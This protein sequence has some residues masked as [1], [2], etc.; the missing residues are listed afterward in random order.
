MTSVAIT[1]DTAGI[2]ND[3]RLLAA[4]VDVDL[5]RSVYR[6]GAMLRTRV[7]AAASGRPGPRVQTG[8]Y[9]R[10][11][12]QTNTREGNVPVAYVHTNMPQG[13][14][15]EYGFTGRDALG[16][17]YDQ[18]PYPHWRPASEKIDEDL[19]REVQASL[20]KAIG[21]FTAGG[22]FRKAGDLID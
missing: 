17:Y 9:R 16:R 13:P 5:S 19:Q 6:A 10:S 12:A 18:P 2:P 20:T 11:I 22:A 1:V 3:L 14:R 8:N 4:T 15:L 21:R 7:R